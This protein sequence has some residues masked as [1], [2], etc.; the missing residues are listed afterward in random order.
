M[1]RISRPKMKLLVSS[2]GWQLLALACVLSCADAVQTTSSCDCN[3]L[4]ADMSSL[5]IAGLLQSNTRTVEDR[6]QRPRDCTCITGVK[7]Y[8]TTPKDQLLGM[9]VLALN[10]HLDSCNRKLEGLEEQKDYAIADSEVKMKQA[11]K[12]TS[13]V[14]NSLD[15]N[16]NVTASDRSKDRKEK[17]QLMKDVKALELEVSDL[18][19][20]YDKHFSTW[21][22]LKESVGSKMK[23]ITSCKCNKA[24]L[25]QR[26]RGKPPSPDA[27]DTARKVEECETKVIKVSK[28]IEA[29]QKKGRDATIVDIE[30]R[31]QLGR[32]MAD[33]ARL[34]KLLSQKPQLKALSKTKQNLESIVKGRKEKI[35]TYT[36][37][38][39]D[40]RQQ[41][42]Q[43][44]TDM[45]SCG[46]AF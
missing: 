20:Q 43:L 39:G 34:H 42:G 26:L 24:L 19:S 1:S 7:T 10:R 46:C 29:A 12:R 21:W 9:G 8:Q 11:S 23:K 14:Q 33:Q 16:K 25:L 35:E 30:K 38:I 37:S 5:G 13:R 32:S 31:E 28:D 3:F 4:A 22:D 6:V 36:K 44:N 41:V 17:Q 18:N 2:A 45:K 15:K 40:L 27:Y